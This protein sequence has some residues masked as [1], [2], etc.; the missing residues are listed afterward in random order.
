MCA[1]SSNSLQRAAIPAVWGEE[2]LSERRSRANC[3]ALE[4]KVWCVV[5]KSVE[6]VKIEDN[7]VPAV[8]LVSSQHGGVGIIRSLGRAGVP[9]YG[10]HQDRWEPAARSRYLRGTF[11]WDFSTA[12][13]PKS[14][15]FLLETARQFGQRPVLIATS[16]ITAVFLADNAEVLANHYLFA[17][18]SAQVVRTF[19]S[20]KETADLCRRL[21]IPTPETAM[22]ACRDDLLSFARA[23]RYP[24]IVKGESGDF[25]QHSNHR[26]R[27]AIVSSQQEL[28]D[29]Y[30]LNAA[31][32]PPSL[33]VQEYIPGGDDT[34]WMFNGY[35]NRRSECVFG[36]AGRKLRQFP[37]HRGHT[38]LGVCESNDTV[39]EQTIQLMQAVGYQGPL[40]IGYRFDARDG[41][42][43]LLDVNP[44]IGATF[45]LFAAENGLDVA[46]AIYL[47][48]TGQDIPPA[49]V[50]PGR[51]WIVESNDLVST[52]N[53]LRER[54]LTV[55]GWLSSLRGVQEGVW[56][57]LDDMAPLATLPFLWLRKHFRKAP[58]AVQFGENAV[59]CAPVTPGDRVA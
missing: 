11:P 18:P 31:N 35:F 3:K 22:P 27:V 8:V 9:V 42:Y 24:V 51:K 57:S 37:V 56:L 6:P 38:T 1:K 53:Y 26:T 7:K 15:E 25:L 28:L 36:A 33:I 46:R 43:K 45:R 30:D 19:A 49:Q 4:T 29:I 58:T 10:V 5:Q 32:K 2:K 39:A 23:T 59:E 48:V 16:D 13:A 20:K 40:D 34:I 44:R 14:V 47:D 52:V 50:C 55:R 21:G 12:Q 54:Q 41:K 17:T